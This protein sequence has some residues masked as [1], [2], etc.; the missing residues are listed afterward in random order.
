M[1]PST[2]LKPKGNYRNLIAFQK[3]ECIYDITYYFAHK[4]FAKGDEDRVMDLC[5]WWAEEA[6]GEHYAPEG[7]QCHSKDKL[8]V[9]HNSKFKIT[10]ALPS[11]IH[12]VE[13]IAPQSGVLG[14]LAEAVHVLLDVLWVDDTCCRSCCNRFEALTVSQFGSTWFGAAFAVHGAVVYTRGSAVCKADFVFLGNLAVDL[15]HRECIINFCHD[16]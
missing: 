8:K 6:R 2:F 14:L 4:Y 9:L 16:S 7:A 12:L 5:Q 13:D 11:L 3:A 10:L 15:V 1:P